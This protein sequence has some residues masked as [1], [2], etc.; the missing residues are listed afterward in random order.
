L[1]STSSPA[2]QGTTVRFA[3]WSDAA[4]TPPLINN[5]IDNTLGDAVK[6]A[7]G[8]T[9]RRIPL[10]ATSDAVFSVTAAAST[11]AAGDIDLIWINGK[12]FKARATR[13]TPRHM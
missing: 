1:L 12:N 6:A 9:M 3:S 13:T 5:Y 11:G 8:I 7:Y 10:A 4:S 2:A